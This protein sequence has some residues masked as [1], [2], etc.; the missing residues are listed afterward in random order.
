MGVFNFDLA[1]YRN[2]FQNPCNT[3]PAALKKKKITIHHYNKKGCYPPSTNAHNLTTV[4][5]ILLARVPM[6]SDSYV[7]LYYL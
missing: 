4:T 3:R 2:S 1:N 5:K 6:N 7:Y